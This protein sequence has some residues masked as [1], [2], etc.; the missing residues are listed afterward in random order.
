MT[1]AYPRP[2][3]RPWG[4]DLKAYIDSKALEVAQDVVNST[5]ENRLSVNVK[6]FGAVGDGIHDDTAAF[7]AAADYASVL[8]IAKIV[9]IPSGTYYLSGQVAVSSHTEWRGLNATLLKKKGGS[10]TVCFTALS[11]G[12]TGYGVAASGLTFRGL[13]FRGSFTAGSEQSNVALAAQH[14][15]DILFEDCNFNEAILSSHTVDLQACRRIHFTRC[16]WRG[17]DQAYAIAHNRSFTEAIQVD[18]STRAGDTATDALGSWDGLP[19]TDVSVVGCSFLPLTVGAT[20]YPSPNPIGSHSH[21]EG[22][23]YDRIWF[24]RN[25]VVSMASSPASGYYGNIH[26][27]SAQN[28]WIEDNIFEWTNTDASKDTVVIQFFDGTSGM[29][30]D[31]VAVENPVTGALATQ[32]PPKNIWVRNNTFKGFKWTSA[33]STGLVTIY[34]GPSG[35]ATKWGSRVFIEG[36]SAED[37]HLDGTTATTGLTAFRVQRCRGVRVAGNEVDTV[38]RLTYVAYSEDVVIQG[39][40]VRNTTSLP[41]YGQN[42]DRILVNGNQVS[43]TTSAY[44]IQLQT[45]T[46]FSVDGNVMVRA[47]GG[48]Y[49]IHLNSNTIG[50]VIGD[51]NYQSGYGGMYDAG[52]GSSL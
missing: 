7:Q 38:R 31:Q 50:G 2:R 30:L 46:S 24:V 9:E 23:I 37:C 35:D 17:W 16:V 51:G 27:V 33:A 22:Q 1:T 10:S 11:N 28:V 49:A 21:V 29:A 4:D 14:S 26:F 36:N 12:H 3:Q 18:C 20:T 40:T 39:N 8:G 52:S 41:I 25:R 44:A 15:D 6:I 5:V 48:T 43:A 47:A 19:T 13:T 34:G 45:C 42:D 32:D